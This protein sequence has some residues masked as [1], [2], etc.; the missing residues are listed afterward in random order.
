MHGSCTSWLLWRS[1]VRL[2]GRH[3]CNWHIS[4]DTLRGRSP[5]PLASACPLW[6]LGNLKRER[7]GYVKACFQFFFFFLIVSVDISSV[8]HKSQKWKSWNGATW[9]KREHL[10]TAA[11]GAWMREKSSDTHEGGGEKVG[12]GARTLEKE[13][14]C[15]SWF[16]HHLISAS[17]VLVLRNSNSFI[18]FHTRDFSCIHCQWVTSILSSENK[19]NSLPGEN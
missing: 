6:L 1:P 13:C 16:S 5:S 4:N 17:P 3:A 18:H 15:D 7:T 12:P 10:A 19:M 9:A 14:T 8:V 11:S 2:L